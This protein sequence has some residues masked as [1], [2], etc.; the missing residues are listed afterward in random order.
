MYKF[1][2]HDGH[3]VMHFISSRGHCCHN[4]WRKKKVFTFQRSSA[5]TTAMKTLSLSLSL[6]VCV[7]A[8]VRARDQPREASREERS[9][10]GPGATFVRCRDV[11]PTGPKTGPLHASRTCL[12]THTHTHTRARARGAAAYVAPLYAVR[13]AYGGQ[14]GQ[15]GPGIRRQSHSGC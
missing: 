8:W 11:P 6:R 7:R 13:V 3:D 4:C 15:P 9:E 12:D 14:G 2:L 1:L 5:A 10:K